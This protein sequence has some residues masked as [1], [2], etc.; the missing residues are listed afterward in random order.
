MTQQDTAIC[1]RLRK[2]HGH[3][4]EEIRLLKE[5][6]REAEQETF[7]NPIE[8]VNVIKNLQ[9]VLNMINH[10]LVKCPTEKE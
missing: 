8:T 4:T 10:E 5:G 6:L 2:L 3:L 9:E 1:K 7:E